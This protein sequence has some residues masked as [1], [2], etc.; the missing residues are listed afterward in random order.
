MILFTQLYGLGAY[1]FEC[2]SGYYGTVQWVTCPSTWLMDRKLG[3][4]CLAAFT[5]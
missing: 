3:K 4:V 2:A 1:Q 5:V